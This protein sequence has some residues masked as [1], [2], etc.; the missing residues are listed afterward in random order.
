MKKLLSFILAMILVFGL[1]ACGE[2][3][4]TEPEQTTTEPAPKVDATATDADKAKLDSLYEGREI[5][6]GEMHAHADTGGNSDGKFTLEQWKAHMAENQ[7]DFA[8]IVDHKQT[9]HMKLDEWDSTMFIGGSEA[10]GA[11]MGSPATNSK[12]HYNMLFATVEE[13]EAFL[14]MQKYLLEFNFA[15]SYFGYHDFNVERMHQL[16]NDVYTN[17]GLFVHVHPQAND[18]YMV[19]DDPLDYFFGDVMGFEVLTGYHAKDMKTES[20]LKQYDTWVKLLNLGKRAY[21]TCGSDAHG[22]L[23][24]VVACLGTIYA[25][26]TEA[27]TLLDYI[28]AGDFVAGPAGIRLSVGDGKMG[29]EVSF[30]GNRLVVAAGEVHYQTYKEDHSYRVDVYDDQGLVFSREIS[31]KEVAYFAI[32]ANP[33]AKYYRADVYD[34]TDEKI[35]AIGNPIWNK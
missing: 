4:P 11:V 10:G 19:S 17:G 14:G 34:V 2:K 32:D 28:R 31:G 3:P 5:R 35:I 9:L 7:V 6:Y 12:L 20:N 33:N 18:T 21:A 29:D 27:K 30:A 24:D 22:S 8:T 15:G 23:V 13:F 1:C 25:E 16:S 26:N